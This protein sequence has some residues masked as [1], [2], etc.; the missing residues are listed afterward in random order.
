MLEST[1]WRR[2]AERVFFLRGAPLLGL[3]GVPLGSQ[4]DKDPAA[5][6]RQQCSSQP[7]IYT[8]VY[9][10]EVAVLSKGQKSFVKDISNHLDPLSK[11]KLQTQRK[12][13]SLRSVT[14]KV[15]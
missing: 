9:K 10:V 13:S 14:V 4:A 11:I 6:H 15:P 2:G 1:V 5:P 3:V 12:T 8:R 7:N